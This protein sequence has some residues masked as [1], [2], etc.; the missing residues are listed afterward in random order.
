MITDLGP[1]ATPFDALPPG[2][3]AGCCYRYAGWWQEGVSP[4]SI[5]N[6]DHGPV[7][8]EQIAIRRVL[9]GGKA[10][11]PIGPLFALVTFDHVDALYLADIERHGVSVH[12]ESRGMLAAA[13][14][15]EIAV[16]WSRYAC[17]SDEKLTPAAAALKRRVLS[18][19]AEVTPS[20][21]GQAASTV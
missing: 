9:V 18:L 17:A 15:D 2:S 12:A 20:S 5:Q 4:V 14:E 11:A 21:S 3:A 1:D 10:I 7:D 13:I 8:L 19:F 6:I 16:P